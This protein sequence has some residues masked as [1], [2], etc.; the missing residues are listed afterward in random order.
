[1]T[2]NVGSQRILA[3]TGAFDGTAYDRMKEA[4]LEEMRGSFRPEFLNR[5]DEIIVFHAL[6]EEHLIK[7]VDIQLERLRTR[8]ADRHIQVDLTPKALRHLVRIGYDAAY[9]A[10]PLKR[11]IQKN[12]E[13]QLGFLLL[14]GKVRDGQKVIVDYDQD[15]DKLLFN[16]QP[17]PVPDEAEAAKA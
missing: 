1:M 8:L 4:V 11:A 10:R 13:T 17:S 15:T 12:L 14:E 5:V 16:P 9:G 7:I 6:S 3:Y 2:S